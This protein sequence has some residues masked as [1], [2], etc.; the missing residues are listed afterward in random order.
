MGL[1]LQTILHISAPTVGS[2]FSAIW[3]GAI[4]AACVAL[5]LR[6]LPDLGAAARSVVWTIVFLLLILLHLLPSL[7]Q[8]WST[9]SMIHHSLIQLDPL[10]GIAI[11]GVWAMLSLWRGVELLGS[12]VRLRK[13][14]GRATPIHVDANLR[15]LLKCGKTGR[16]AELCA[17]AEV[18][19]PSV[20]GFFRPR[21]LLPQVLIERL[22]A[23]ELRQIVLHEMEHLRRGDDWMNLFQKLGLVLFPMNPVLLWVERRLCVER[24]HACDDRVLHSTGARKAYALCLT[25]MAEYS[26]LRRNL[27]LVLGAWERQSE[28]V[29]RVHRILRNPKEAMSGKR[30]MFLTGSL[31]LGVLVG[32]IALARSP[33]LVGFAPR[34]QS[35]IQAR[36]MP[37]T[38]HHEVRVR[39]SNGSPLLVKAIMPPRPLQTSYISN[40]PRLVAAKRHVRRPLAHP[41]QTAWVVLTEWEDAGPPPRLVFTITQDHRSSYAAVTITNGWLIIQI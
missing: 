24:E 33:Q 28:L 21:I 32:A 8:H 5:C 38:G 27:S 7:D 22:S 14:A 17:S 3:E 34:A 29:R 11:A 40:H 9:D 36:F 2:L 18:E 10:W 31:I 4:L 35:T 41:N 37:A 26:M 39:E 15:S 23:I 6:M 1:L 19:R 12:A 20:L 25:R 13:L 30:A 16:T